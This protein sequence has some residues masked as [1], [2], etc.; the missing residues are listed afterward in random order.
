MLYFLTFN[1]NGRE[2][3]GNA[4]SSETAAG[5]TVN[6]LLCGKDKFTWVQEPPSVG[7]RREQDVI[8]QVPGVTALARTNAKS[9][10]DTYQFITNEMVDNIVL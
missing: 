2:R 3:R 6:Q 7:H 4:R 10:M 8:R 1:V 9:I 5:D